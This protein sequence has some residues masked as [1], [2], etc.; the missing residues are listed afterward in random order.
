MIYLPPLLLLIATALDIWTTLEAIKRGAVE[1]NPIYGTKRPSLKRLLIV[2]SVV[3]IPMVLLAIAYPSPVVTVVIG[4]VSV[5]LLFV[6]YRNHR[7]MR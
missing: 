4:A 3:T 1:A 5:L 7:V 2:K 6:S